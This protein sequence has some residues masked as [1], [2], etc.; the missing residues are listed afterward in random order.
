MLI[1][2]VN[3]LVYA[4][5]ADAPFHAAAKA[6]WETRL[7]EDEPVGMGCHAGVRSH[8]VEPP[9]LGSADGT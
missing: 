6:W 8:H 7:S 4:Y 1:P 3:L 2:D 5:N 9:S